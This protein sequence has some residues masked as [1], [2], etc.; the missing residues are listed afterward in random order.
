MSAEEDGEAP[1]QTDDAGAEDGGLGFGEEDV[2]ED[3]RGDDEGGDAIVRAEEAQDA[4]T[5]GDEPG[6]VHAAGGQEVGVAGLDEGLVGRT[7]HG[8]ALGEDHRGDDAG[9]GVVILKRGVDNVAPQ[10][11]ADAREPALPADGCRLGG[12]LDRF[13]VVTDETRAD[14]IAFLAQGPV[15][16][17]G[18]A[19]P[20]WSIKPAGHP[21]DIAGTERQDRRFDGD[22]NFAADGDRPVVTIHRFCF[23]DESSFRP[24]LVGQHGVRL[25]LGD[26]RRRKNLA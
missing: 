8:A 14:A 24:D 15:V 26:F 12:P 20:A 11:G 10:A 16:F 7:V 21:D 1:E 22:G 13:G 6:D 3:E 17:A 23:D 4:P 18:V 5:D 9:G 2:G 19:W 25:W